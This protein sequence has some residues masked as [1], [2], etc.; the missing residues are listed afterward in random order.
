MVNTKPGRIY[1]FTLAERLAHWNHALSFLVLFV[2]GGAL[3]FRGLTALMDR[4]TLMLFGQIHRWA[5]GFFA[6]LTIPLLYFGARK[7]ARMWL[8][9]SFRFD[10]DDATFLARFWRDFFGLKAD[11]PPQ[12]KFNAGEKINSVLQ[13]LGWPVMVATGWTLVYKDVF[14]AGLIRWVLAVHSFT[15][16][17]LGAAVIG[18]IYLATLHPHSRPGLS[19]M[20][21]GWVPLRWARAHYRKWV[22]SQEVGAD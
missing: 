13:I 16:L 2:T 6:L 18:H 21:S 20:F 9:D 3:V 4:E 11:L 8:R 7:S 5:G 14:A 12:G 1:R 15:A 19:G 22:E 17:M 10:R